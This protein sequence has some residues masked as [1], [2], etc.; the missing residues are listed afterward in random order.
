MQNYKA[1]DNTHPSGFSL[2]ALSAQ[3]IANGGESYLPAGFEAIT[4]EAAEVIRIANAPTPVLPTPQEQI[5]A[6]ERET[7]MNR[8]TRELML[9][10]AEKEAA[11]LGLTPEQLY[12]ANVAYRSVKDV[13]MQIAA[14]R[15][16]IGVT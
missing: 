1:P 6:I 7:L 2:H 11:A 4:D 13:D 16:Q 14:L 12:V 3:D 5:A 15:A 10:I 9:G 8:A